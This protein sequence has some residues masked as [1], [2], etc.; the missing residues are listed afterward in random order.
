MLNKANYLKFPYSASMK[1]ILWCSL[2]LKKSIAP[3]NKIKFYIKVVKLNLQTAKYRM[4]IK[5]KL[6]ATPNCL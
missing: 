4:G 3:N 6:E 2:K 1:I 5:H